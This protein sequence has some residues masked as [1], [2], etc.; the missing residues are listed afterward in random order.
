[1]FKIL[2][3][4]NGQTSMSQY[5]FVLLMALGGIVAITVHVQRTLQ[6][7]IRDTAIYMVNNVQTITEVPI[8]YQ[9]EPYYA[10]VSTIVGRSRNEETMLLGGGAT[11]IFRKDIDGQIF[12][13]T[14]SEQAPPKDVNKI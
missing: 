9:Y 10:N 4:N 6:A 5:V 7:R 13:V 11:G 8:S 2:C 14:N 3:R 12:V 1:M